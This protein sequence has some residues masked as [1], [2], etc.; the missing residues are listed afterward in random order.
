MEFLEKI[1]KAI[2]FLETEKVEATN[3]CLTYGELKGILRDILIEKYSTDL[4]A[5]NL[6]DG[7]KF[8]KSLKS[9]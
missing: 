5:K 7:M 2:K 8:S 3:V 9:K 1:E 4:S 6:R